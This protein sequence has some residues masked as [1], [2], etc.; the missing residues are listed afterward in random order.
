MNENERDEKLIGAINDLLSIS[1]DS[2]VLQ[3][4]LRYIKEEVFFIMGERDGLKEVIRKH[5]RV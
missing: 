2:V 5:E 1:T 3:K 4:S